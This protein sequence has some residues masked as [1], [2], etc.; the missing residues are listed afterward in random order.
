MA[1]KKITKKTVAFKVEPKYD[2]ALKVMVDNAP[3][4]L[5]VTNK[6]LLMGYILKGFINQIVNDKETFVGNE[7]E[8]KRGLHKIG[9]NE[10]SFVGMN[11]KE[12]IQFAEDMETVKEL[13]ETLKLLKEEVANEKAELDKYIKAKS[14]LEGEIESLERQT[15]NRFSEYKEEEETDYGTNEVEVIQVLNLH[16]EEEMLVNVT[17]EDL[18]EYAMNNGIE[19]QDVGYFELYE[20][21]INLIIQYLRDM[22]IKLST[23]KPRLKKEIEKNKFEVETETGLVVYT[24]ILGILSESERRRLELEENQEDVECYDEEE[25]EEIP[26]H[27]EEETYEEPKTESTQIDY[28]FKII[29]KSGATKTVTGQLK[30]TNVGNERAMY[31]T[32]IGD[33]AVKKGISKSILESFFDYQETV[34]YMTNK[35]KEEEKMVF[36]VKENV[37]GQMKASGV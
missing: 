14:K 31:N 6:S 4:Y 7:K 12:I 37:A 25:Y 27:H 21:E 11:T 30:N 20:E 24:D 22:G 9:F 35:I 2:E 13:E 34:E 33:I 15:D 23:R 1:E 8:M 18:E 32:L 10:K 26:D 17:P 3:S 19:Y 5:P 16:D 29:P 28:E 36:E